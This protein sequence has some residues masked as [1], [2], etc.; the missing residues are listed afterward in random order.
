M[1]RDRLKLC[2]VV[3]LVGLSVL[4]YPILAQAQVTLP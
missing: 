2:F 1:Y 4:G 3:T